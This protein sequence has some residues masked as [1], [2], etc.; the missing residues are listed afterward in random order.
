MR[1][2][3]GVIRDTRLRKKLL[4]AAARSDGRDVD[5]LASLDDGS[6]GGMSYGS[7]RSGVSQLTFR[8]YASLVPKAVP[9]SID[10]PKTKTRIMQTSREAT[11]NYSTNAYVTST[12]QVLSTPSPRRLYRSPRR[13]AGPRGIPVVV[14]EQPFASLLKTP[15]RNEQSPTKQST[16]LGLKA[17]KAS[18]TVLRRR[19]SRRI[20]G[21]GTLN[22]SSNARYA[23]ADADDCRRQ[24]SSINESDTPIGASKSEEEVAP[25]NATNSMSEIT[26]VALEVIQAHLS[27]LRE[28]EE[29][30]SN[31]REL[32]AD[33]EKIADSSLMNIDLSSSEVITRL[34]SLSEEQV[35]D[36][37]E[38]LHGCINKQLDF[39]EMF[40]CQMEKISQGG[41]NEDAINKEFRDAAQ[42]PEADRFE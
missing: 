3:S 18:S 4:E 31:E 8:S 29:A 36:Y 6:V 16:P 7:M 35:C 15:L 14:T 39:S 23:D 28:L 42:S 2:H 5:D 40:L 11:S 17:Q 37:F 13:S 9:N 26:T 32:L 30:V 10:T 33:L 34:A 38:S 12:G 19:L 21:V 25:E 1:M 24:L 22:G 27:H 41:E 20:S